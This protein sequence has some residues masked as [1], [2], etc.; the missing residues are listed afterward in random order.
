MMATPVK[1]YEFELW[2]KNNTLVADITHLAKN[3]K[4]KITRNAPETLE[5]DLDLKAFENLCASINEAPRNVLEADVTTVKVKRMG[6]YMFGV[7]VKETPISIDEAGKKIDVKCLGFLSQLADRYVA[8]EYGIKDTP[9]SNVATEDIVWDLINTTQQT[10]NGNFGFTRG[11]V[12]ATGVSRYRKYDGQT[13]VADAIVNLSKLMTG[14]F[15]FKI[16]HDKVFHMYENLGSIRDDVPLT[17][18]GNVQSL[19]V[20][21]GASNL[22]NHIDG[23]GSGFGDEAIK[24]TF[25]DAFSQITYGRREKLYIASDVSVQSTLDEQT[26]A[27]GDM[28]REIL[29]IPKP[30]VKGTDL[31]LGVVGIGDFL[32]FKVTGHTFVPIDGRYRIDELDVSLDD[33]LFETIVISF[34][35]YGVSA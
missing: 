12:Y 5:F 20:P 33:N 27:Y 11:N 15:D 2:N 9:S 25:D 35:D 17:Y 18:P 16:T 24:S 6:V 4:F 13:S 28:R 26:D 8:K 23:Y 7:E 19:E 1:R 10:A 32:P 30:K 31:D 29:E 14:R 22:F 3:I 34:D 21:R